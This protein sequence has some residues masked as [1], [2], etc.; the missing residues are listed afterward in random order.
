MST[1]AIVGMVLGIVGAL[2]MG[3]FIGY[4]WAASAFKKQ[5][6]NNP[7]IN[8]QQIRAMYAQMGRKPSESQ[9]RQIMNSYK[10]QANK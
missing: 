9:I 7:P 3:A 2:I 5:L 4:R 1:G 10:S 6:K 8:E